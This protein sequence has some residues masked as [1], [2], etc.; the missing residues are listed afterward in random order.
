[1][2]KYLDD[3][4]EK[5]FSE[6]ESLR[7]K[8]DIDEFFNHAPRMF[9]KARHLTLICII[10]L[11]IIVLLSSSAESNVVKLCYDIC[12]GLLVS[13]VVALVFVMRDNAIGYYA[14]VVDIIKARVQKIEEACVEANEH[15]MNRSADEGFHM[16]QSTA[17]NAY[18]F[19]GYLED[20]FSYMHG[21][22]LTKDLYHKVT[23]GNPASEKEREALCNDSRRVVA[24]ILHRLRRAMILFRQNACGKDCWEV[25]CEK[26]QR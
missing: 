3:F 5:H 25:T 18:E 8:T 22:E 9:F 19:A 10:L 2:D 24:K 20:R 23:I 26:Q 17:Q 16:L 21:L 4:C 14:E 1:M 7:I 15:M 6:F 11:L 12:L 13:T